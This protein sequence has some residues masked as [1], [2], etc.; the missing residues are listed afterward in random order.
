MGIVL[1]RSLFLHLDSEAD[2]S[3]VNPCYRLHCV[4][5][6]AERFF[7]Q[8]P[9]P[10]RYVLGSKGVA[11]V[12]KRYTLSSCLKKPVNKHGTGMRTFCFTRCGG[13]TA[14]PNAPFFYS[15]NPT[16]TIVAYSFMSIVSKTCG[17]AGFKAHSLP[18]RTPNIVLTTLA[19]I[20]AQPSDHYNLERPT[21]E[22]FVYATSRQSGF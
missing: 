9:F 13:D 7:I 2:V 1:P 8:T 18:C 5:L 11:Y 22:H 15:E 17:T 20:A 10:D 6:T 14:E 4:V 19:C 3:A 16:T 12:M 21:V